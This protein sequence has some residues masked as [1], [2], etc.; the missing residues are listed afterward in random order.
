MLQTPKNLRGR[1]HGFP[2]LNFEATAHIMTIEADMT[3]YLR[4][5]GFY[6]HPATRTLFV[7]VG[8]SSGDNFYGSRKIEPLAFDQSTIAILHG[9]K[10]IS[11]PPSI[12]RRINM[13]ENLIAMSDNSIL[14]GRLEMH[15]RRSRKRYEQ[16]RL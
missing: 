1:S 8:D 7:W 13:C 12:V 3:Q 4:F 6:R 10:D 9:S 15:H 14:D 11:Q 2:D 16:K 5:K